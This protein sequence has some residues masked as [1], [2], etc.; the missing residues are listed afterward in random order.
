MKAGVFG[1]ASKRSVPA[2]A[3][4]YF[5]RIFPVFATLPRDTLSPSTIELPT[6]ATNE[7]DQR[8]EERSNGHG[9][10]RL[11][12]RWNRTSLTSELGQNK[13]SQVSC[14]PIIEKV[15]GSSEQLQRNG[16][17]DRKLINPSGCTARVSI[18]VEK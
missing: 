10:S 2:V 8:S 4:S 1:L 17:S 15:A 13:R 14:V 3:R 7:L 18:P 16:F 11:R 12:R 5:T 9:K 6:P